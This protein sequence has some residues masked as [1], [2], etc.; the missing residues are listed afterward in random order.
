MFETVVKIEKGNVV[1]INE[2]QNYVDLKNGINRLKKDSINNIL[3]NKIKVY[4]WT[5]KEK[6]DCGELYTIIIGKN[7]KVSEILMTDYQNNDT[8]SKYWDSKREYNFCINS[9]KKALKKLQ[10][11]I[12]KRKGIPIEEKI[13]IEI[14]FNE[15]GTIENWTN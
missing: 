8:I 14:W 4:K 11:D 3:F 15:D 9:M 2:E 12:I 6:F 1:E 7:G 5:K 13:N 10:F